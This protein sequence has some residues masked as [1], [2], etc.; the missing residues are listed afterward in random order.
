MLEL[1]SGDACTNKSY[2]LTSRKRARIALQRK[3]KLKGQGRSE[4]NLALHASPNPV[5]VRTSR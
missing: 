3:V 5:L 4:D 2:A 1:S